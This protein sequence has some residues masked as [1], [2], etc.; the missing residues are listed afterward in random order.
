MNYSLNEQLANLQEAKANLEKQTKDLESQLEEYSRSCEELIDE[1]LSMRCNL[2]EV[3]L[4]LCEAKQQ[5]WVRNARE[6]ASLSLFA[7][8]KVAY[9]LLPAYLD[10]PEK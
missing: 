6:I 4:E 2:N 8:Q 7:L 1:N 10:R 3:T 9:L 5:T